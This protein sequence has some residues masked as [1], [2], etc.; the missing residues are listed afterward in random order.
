MSAE[1][2][3]IGELERTIETLVAYLRRLP[4]NPETYNHANQAEGVLRKSVSDIS[5]S[6]QK[7]HP[8]GL[9]VLTVEM[10][11][12]N[13]TVRTQDVAGMPESFQRK[14]KDGLFDALVS[15]IGVTLDGK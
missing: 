5:L 9:A 10:K 4:I 2:A 1:S 6:G 13:I 3:R 15:G 14:Y 8:S 11:G 12:L 7:Y